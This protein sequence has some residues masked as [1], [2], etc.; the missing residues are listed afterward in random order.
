MAFSTST[1]LLHRLHRA[2]QIATERFASELGDADL[3][4]CQ[5]IVLAAIAADEGASQT[6]IVEATGVDRSTLTDIVKRLLRRG[7][8]SRRRTKEDARAYALKLTEAGRR[9]LESAVPVMARVE[10]EMLTAIPAKQ[11][12]ELINLLGTLTEREKT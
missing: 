11:R 8:L 1:S 12:A 10:A 7:L 3:T 2:S 4:P 9:A 6:T 5:I